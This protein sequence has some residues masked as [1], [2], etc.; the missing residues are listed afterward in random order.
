M[1]LMRASA[2]GGI[3]D[4][5]KERRLKF[6]GPRTWRLHIIIPVLLQLA[7]LLF[8]AGIVVY[9]WGLDPSAAQVTLAVSCTGFLFYACVSVVAIILPDFPFQTPV[10]IFFRKVFS[11]VKKF[12]AYIRTRLRRRSAAPSQRIEMSFIGPLYKA[13]RRTTTPD[14]VVENVHDPMKLSNPAFWR[15]DPLFTSP[16]PKHTAASAGFW[17][18]ENSADS[19]AAPAVAA[20]F[21]ELQWQ[22]HHHSATAL[23]RLHDTYKQCLRAHRFDKFVR[24]KALQSAAAY[25]VLY[26][27]WLIRSASKSR[28]A[29][30][31]K[32]PDLP[33][34]LLLHKTREEWH[35]YDLFE[36]LLHFQ[37][38]SESVTSA[39]FLSYIAPYWFCGDSEFTIRFRSSRLESL[40]DLIAVLEVSKALDPATLT[41]CVLC[42]GAAMDFPLHPEDLIR[43][44]KRYVSLSG[45][46]SKVVLIWDSDYLS[47][48]FKM[49]VEHI[50]EITLGC[51]RNHDDAAQA[52]DILLTLAKHALLPLVDAAWINELLTRAAESDMADEE[53]TLFL[54]LSARRVG[55]FGIDLQSLR[56]TM[57]S[58][59]PTPDDTLFCKVMKNIQACAERGD[60]TSALRDNDFEAIYGGLLA[61]RDIPRLGLALFDDGTLQTFY[62]AVNHGNPIRV[63]QAAYDVML[64]TRDLWLKSE[65]LRQ[66]LEDLD[67]FRQLH[68]V[69]IETTRPDYQRSFL[70]MMELLSE[71]VHWHSYLR[72]DMGIWL[73]HR[74]EGMWHALRILANVGG[75]PLPPVLDIRNLLSYD[76]LLQSLVL[77][78]WERVLK[79]HVRDL[80]ADGLKP[81]VEVT[82]QFRELLFDKNYQRAVLTRIN[83]VAQRLEPS[84]GNYD[85]PGGD[86]RG[87]VNDLVTKLHLPPRRPPSRM[88]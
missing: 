57:T 32:P 9:L 38:C 83:E 60:D 78:E 73:P 58:E 47:P 26:H 86:V 54:R 4:R 46:T 22:P 7:L 50:C 75:L 18:L 88:D 23:I 33:S 30:V 2:W 37:D 72:K 43:V 63:K 79:R 17:L 62:G 36:Y 67:F 51:G 35:G 16:L 10:S 31:E 65:G 82:E 13:F 87:I 24:L 21:F 5:G 8:S 80:T 39:R 76:R 84:D 19:S 29:E 1:L 41:D 6:V 27:T 15:Q 64:V 45:G 48:T 74:H 69:V 71:D 56:K 81:L 85:G 3:T 66:R 40:Y 59:A 55:G 11:W 77:D 44:D 68:S 49:V 20:V 25:Y 42:V 14:Q 12:V 34:D 28:G 70:L 61:I 52:L 53:F